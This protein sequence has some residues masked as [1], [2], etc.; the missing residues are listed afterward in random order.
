M[1]DVTGC[2]GTL[3][4]MW[5][6]P[7]KQQTQT[8]THTHTHTH[9]AWDTV[10]ILFH[11]LLIQSSLMLFLFLDHRP[12]D[13]HRKVFV[14]RPRPHRAYFLVKPHKYCAYGPTVQTDPADFFW[15]EPAP[16]SPLEYVLQR[17]YSLMCFRNKSVFT[18]IFLKRIVFSPV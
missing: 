1:K 14:L 17:F 6:V 12:I 10:G 18:E 2:R 13:F 5:A 3:C 8:H 9:V 16:H 15:G 11:S 4:S 7:D